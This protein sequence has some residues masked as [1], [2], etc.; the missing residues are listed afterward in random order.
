MRVGRES[1]WSASA[2]A[3]GVLGSSWP[4]TASAQQVVVV[5]NDRGARCDER[6]SA[7]AW[8]DRPARGP[9]IV[10]GIGLGVAKMVESGPFGFNNGV[11]SVTDAGPAWVLTGGVEF[12]RWLAV[13]ARYSA[14]YTAV[15]ASTGPGGSFGFVSNGIAATL[16]LTAPFPYVRPYIFGGLGYYDIA[17]AGSASARAASPLFSSSQ[18]GIPMGFGIDIPLMWHLSIGAEAAYHFQ[19]GESYSNSMVNGIDGGDITTFTGMMRLRL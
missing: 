8:C 9:R 13:E 18:A 7:T 2:L 19:L 1:F 3:L 14:S 5:D 10:L 17:L 4:A 15:E 11:G 16:R 12:T 6:W